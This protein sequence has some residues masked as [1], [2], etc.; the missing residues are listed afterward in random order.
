MDKHNQ[1]NLTVVK[2][3]TLNRASYSLTLDERRLILSSIAQLNSR[4][5]MLEEITIHASEFAH[6]W[7]ISEKHA[8]KQLKDARNNLYERNIRLKKNGK[9]TDMRWLDSASYVDG[10]GYI[11]LSFTKK[12]SPY[13]SE[14]NGFYSSYRLMEVRNF[15]SGHAIRLYELMMQFKETGWMDE[16]VGELKEIFG[17]ADKYPSWYEF[18]RWV[19]N[20]AVKEINAVTNY[21]LKY[22]TQKRGRNISRVK[23]VFGRNEQTDMFK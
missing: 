9:V 14:L 10:E 20:P 12:I 22:S 13:L 1:N 2:H 4:E 18:R 11:S 5:K 3:N 8:Y 6:Q 21:K 16:S 17:V 23:F 7:G 19:I 15:K